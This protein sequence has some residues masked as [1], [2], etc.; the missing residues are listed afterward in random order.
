MSATTAI[1]AQGLV[2]RFACDPGFMTILLGVFLTLCPGQPRQA[3]QRRENY[4]D[5]WER[6]PADGPDEVAAQAMEVLK[7]ANKELARLDLA[8]REYAEGERYDNR[9]P[10]S[11]GSEDPAAIDEDDWVRPPRREIAR[12]QRPVNRMPLSVGPE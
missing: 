10:V 3:F 11:V 8:N 7:N 9:A 4:E 12:R 2:S 1:L 6:R 5:Q